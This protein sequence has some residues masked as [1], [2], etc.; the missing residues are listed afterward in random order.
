M[1]SLLW[2]T[3]LF[4]FFSCIYQ[5]SSAQNN[6][7]DTTSQKL[8]EVIIRS[9]EQNTRLKDIPA[10]VNYIGKNVFDRYRNISSVQAVN[11]SPGARMEERSPGSYRF[12]IRGSSLRSPF[13]VRN[14]KVYYNDLI[15]TDPTG[16]TYLNQLGSYNL[17]SMEIIKGPGSSLYG[18]GTGGVLLIRSIDDHE[19]PGAGISYATGSYNLQNLYGYL[20]TES[21]KSLNKI[22]YQHQQ[23]EG[24]RDQSKLKR[25]VLNWNGIYHTGEKGQV[26]TT[27]LYGKLF[28]ETP[29]G[30][31]TTEFKANP[32]QARPAAGGFPSAEAAQASITQT[33]FL[34]GASYTQQITN[35]WN[36]K[37]SLYG[38][39]TELNNPAIR[40]YG[41]NSEPHT[42]ARTLFQYIDSLP[43]GRLLL[44]FGG[45]WQQGFAKE[46]VY[47]NRSGNPD[48]LQ[49]ED[50]V[51]S[52]QF[53]AFAQMVLDYRNWMLTGGGSWNDY[54]I[55]FQRFQPSALEKQLMEFNN[56]ISPRVSLSKKL[57]RF[58]IYTSLSKGFSP[59]ATA[60]LFPTGSAVN[61]DLKPES[62]TNYD[63]GARGS[64]FDGL[65]ADI[66]IFTYTL[67]NTIVQR[68][69]AGGGDYYVNAGSTKQKGVETLISY[70]FLQTLKQVK[71]SSLWLSHTWHDFHY[72][73]FK[74]QS[75]DYSGNRM[76][77]EAPHSISAGF[78]LALRNGIYGMASLFYSGKIPLNDA[79]TAYA[80]AYHIIDVKAG[81][82]LL[83]KNLVMDISAGGNNLLNETYSL[84]NDINAAGGRYYNAVPGRNYFICLSVGWTKKAFIP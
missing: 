36:N 10:A 41:S 33:S 47:K 62:G 54:R 72:Q 45:E 27:F 70:P 15:L 78:D 58:T 5:F 51:H 67:K 21:E 23:S 75:T 61:L 35:N 68:R 49:T 25:D 6:Q 76:P 55:G 60:E 53:S 79:N 14:V 3:T 38:M 56:E 8:E 28:Y 19:Q 34:A 40:N 83:I 73:S 37:T 82:Q 50:Q 44:D 29:G 63:L 20:T 64:F 52:R 39:F 26:Q 46:S 18:A 16:N 12:T 17:N 69:D 81:Y 24:Y 59:P 65:Y 71:F 31:T 4:L 7:P 84:G 30:L 80:N 48:S 74:Q 13:G 57:N 43:N 1:P 77:G 42:G 22:S 32:K 11:T 9:Y 2:K 66:N